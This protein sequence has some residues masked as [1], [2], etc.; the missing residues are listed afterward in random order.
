MTH[1][2]WRGGKHHGNSRAFSTLRPARAPRESA[3][4]PIPPQGEPRLAGRLPGPSLRSR[5]SA[6]PRA[7]EG[8]NPRAPR[9]TSSQSGALWGWS[10]REGAGLP[11]RPANRRGSPG[12][13]GSGTGSARPA[14]GMDP[15][16][17]EFLAEKELVTVVPNFSLDRIYLIGV[18]RA[19]A[20]GRGQTGRQKR[21]GGEVWA[22]PGEGQGRLWGR[23]QTRG[24]DQK[25]GGGAS[26]GEEKGRSQRAGWIRGGA[27]GRHFGGGPCERGQRGG[28]ETMRDRGGGRGQLG[29]R[30]QR[31]GR[32]QQGY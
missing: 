31:G 7:Q 9:E 13:S 6:N 24:R 28:V 8:A 22:G 2:G 14:P 29:G 17:A 27:R 32:G 4:W 25:R 12:G 21:G 1:G 11:A 23:G 16:E 26:L 10:P 20:C 3:D 30:G 19:R 5:A 18:R 15:A